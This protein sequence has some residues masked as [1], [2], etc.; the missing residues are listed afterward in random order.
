MAVSL[1]TEVLDL[2]CERSLSDP[3]LDY[4]STLSAYVCDYLIFLYAH[5]TSRCRK[6]PSSINILQI[7]PSYFQLKNL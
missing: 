2:S 7:F 1:E 3:S 5:I 6:L 4:I